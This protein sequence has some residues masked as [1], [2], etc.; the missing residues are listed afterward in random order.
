MSILI[1]FIVILVCVMMITL[2]E[3]KYLGYLQRRVG[4]VYWGKFGILQRVADGLKLYVKEVLLSV[5]VLGVLYSL[6]RII[7]IMISI[8]IYSVLPVYNLT[9]NCIVVYRSNYSIIIIFIVSSLS[10]Y[11]I[12][13]SGLS[14]NNMYSI[15][16]SLRCISQLISYEVYIGIILIIILLLCYY[17][18]IG[19]ILSISNLYRIQ[20]EYSVI[21]GFIV[22]FVIYIISIIGETNRSRLDI[23]EAESELVSGWNTEY[24]AISFAA[25][26]IGEYSII[27]VLS[28]LTSIIFF[29]TEVLVLSSATLGI[30]F[31]FI[32]SRGTLPRLKQDQLLILGWKYILIIVL[33][34]VCII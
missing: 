7:F 26:M 20:V 31:T 22:I 1:I 13:F 16:G 19:Q 32:L 3:R 29:K 34:Y 15:I 23:S 28:Y 2:L 11:S 12:L 30:I 24:S 5:L 6:T 10:S 18:N 27:I 4:R 21:I 8:V 25:F 17:G 33:A 9:E 14:S